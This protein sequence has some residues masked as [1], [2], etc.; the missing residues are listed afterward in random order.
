M[1]IKIDRANQVVS[2]ELFDETIKLVRA[3]WINVYDFW[4]SIHL[5]FRL[6]RNMAIYVLNL[7]IYC[8]FLSIR[9]RSAHWMR[10]RSCDLA[11]P[12]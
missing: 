5:S 1:I 2:V 6:P 4:T 7:A 8:A 3:R 11:I 12:P 9:A 10:G